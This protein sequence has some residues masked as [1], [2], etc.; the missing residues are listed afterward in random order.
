MRLREYLKKY[1]IVQR[2]M[3][4]KLGITITH[5]RMLLNGKASPSKKLAI[6]IEKVTNGEVSKESAIF[7]EDYIEKDNDETREKVL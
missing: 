6:K 2:V 4:D 1:T 3:A 5:L 7:F